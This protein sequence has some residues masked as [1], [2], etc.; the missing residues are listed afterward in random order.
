M[1]A[2]AIFYIKVQ[3]CDMIN[4]VISDQ[5]QCNFESQWK[6][7]VL[8]ARNPY[9]VG[10]KHYL[11]TRQPVP[12][13]GR[14]WC[15]WPVDSSCPRARHM[16]AVVHWRGQT[17]RISISRSCCGFNVRW[18]SCVLIILIVIFILSSYFKSQI[19][20]YY[21]ETISLC[22]FERKL[23]YP[24]ISSEMLRNISKVHQFMEYQNRISNSRRI[25]CVPLNAFWKKSDVNLRLSICQR[26]PYV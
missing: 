4:I 18:W 6:N 8:H 26:T 7:K 24:E 22:F 1:F 12:R 2:A 19:K 25:L 14:Y 16:D 17:A 5:V 21:F 13:K 10:W 20:L 9:T 15:W 3:I 11:L 23:A